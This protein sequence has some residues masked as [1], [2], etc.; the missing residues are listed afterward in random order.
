M[1]LGSGFVV[2]PTDANLNSLSQEYLYEDVHAATEAFSASSRL[3]QG[4]YGSVYQG[5][6]RDGTEVAVK[7]LSKPNESGFREEVE[8]LSKFRHPNLVI[9]MGF[10][11]HAQE[12]Y[13]IYE[14]LPGG[15]VCARLQKDT[16]FTWLP[17]IHVACDSALGLSH[18]H[19]A[20]P[21]VFHRD[22]KTQ[23]ILMDRNG[24]GKMADFGLALLAQPG[25]SDAS[26]E[27]TS[28]TVGYADPLYIRTGV[29]TEG[30]E[31]Y[32]FGMVL[33][34]LLTRRPPALQHVSG[35]IEYQFVHLE[36]ELSRVKAMLDPRAMWPVIVS[37][38]LGELALRCISKQEVNRPSF[39]NIVK[40]L[41][42]LIRENP[43]SSP[44][45]TPPAPAA[46]APPAPAAVAKNGPFLIAGQTPSWAAGVQDRPL[47]VSGAQV[48]PAVQQGYIQQEKQPLAPLASQER[49]RPVVLN[50]TPIANSNPFSK[51]SSAD[52]DRPDRQP[53]VNLARASA[54][55]SSSRPA[56]TAEG[57]AAPFL[58]PRF[59]P[60]GS[61]PL[62]RR[63]GDSKVNVAS[64]QHLAELQL[65]AESLCKS[66]GAETVDST[67]MAAS[68][69]ARFAGLQQLRVAGGMQPVNARATE[70]QRLV[71]NPPA[72]V[73]RGLIGVVDASVDEGPDTLLGADDGGIASV[74]DCG[75]A[76]DFVGSET[77]P[78]GGAAGLPSNAAAWIDPRCDP[79]QGGKPFLLPFAVRPDGG[80]VRALWPQQQLG[81]SE[82]EEA[83]APTAVVPSTNSK[84]P[85]EQEAMMQI[86]QDEMHFT[87][88]QV[89]EAFKR[90][91]TAEAA[92]DWILE[93]GREWGDQWQG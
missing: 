81:T 91:S 56:A 12:R 69:A 30:S 46:A 75:A 72:V 29:V 18:L 89:V 35:R 48:R 61:S 32:S 13:L 42:Q 93:P 40:Q 84:T 66:T 20:R 70:S 25:C 15:D 64:G 41:R 37:T 50:I 11:R 36:G 9:L 63:P 76:G 5:T 47:Q 33:L 26:V 38:G 16:T 74:L 14:L 86:L 28:G 49:P 77:P 90:C 71:A 51:G 1:D 45:G 59:K 78:K 44:S 52:A 88:Y 87:R 68:N 6:L 4:T 23:N 92:I 80:A 7:Q 73:Q 10:A 58:L 27:H 62:G 60:E 31:V 65:R 22:I 21:Q 24:T 57:G 85:E 39:I 67:R 43:N 19:C 8:V 55:S 17:R 82:T 54:S 3:G 34:E 2:P 83:P 79:L 53:A